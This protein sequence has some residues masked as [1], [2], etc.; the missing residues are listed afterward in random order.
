MNKSNSQLLSGVFKLRPNKRKNAI[1][2]PIVSIFLGLL[3]FSSFIFPIQI[4][5]YNENSTAQTT[6]QVVSQYDSADTKEYVHYFFGKSTTWKENYEVYGESI[7][8]ANNGDCFFTGYIKTEF[9]TK[10]DI[11]FGKLNESGTLQWINRYDYQDRD[12]AYDLVLDDTNAYVIGSTLN[13]SKIEYTELFVGCYDLQNGSEVWTVELGDLELS[14]IGFSLILE[15]NTLYVAGIKSQYIQIQM[16]SDVFLAAFNKETG[17]LDWW[18]DFSTSFYDND[19]TLIFS[20]KEQIFYLTFNRKNAV[21]NTTL[22]VIKVLTKLGEL[23][24]EFTISSFDDLIINDFIFDSENDQL[25]FIG[26][27]WENDYQKFRDTAIIFM[28]TDGEL[29]ANITLGEEEINEEGYSLVLESSNLIIAGAANSDHFNDFVAFFMK[30]TREGRVIWE[31]KNE[32]YLRSLVIDLTI[33]ENGKIAM[34]GFC[35][36]NWDFVYHRLFICY[37]IDEDDDGL[38]RYYE[39]EIGTNPLLNDTDSDGFSDGDEVRLNTDPLNKNSNIR[40]RFFWNNVSIASFF[41]VL[42]IFMIINAF[43]FTNKKADEKS[44]IVN[45]YERFVKLFRMKKEE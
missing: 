5:G 32:N 8:F 1:K 39:L 9:L 27:F 22:P 44:P 25:I 21:T 36:S 4:F 29:I 45:I 2:Q 17:E 20:E 40:I 42:F 14:E 24:E 16:D 35:E 28:D 3:L 10:S 37:T 6:E 31:G 26:D 34:A 38:S 18:N 23:E 30:I 11:V 7:K 15:E 19:P 41:V 43:L 13:N 33:A 12:I